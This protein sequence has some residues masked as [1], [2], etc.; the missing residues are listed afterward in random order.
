MRARE[1]QGACPVCKGIKRVAVEVPEELLITVEGC[2][3]HV[4]S[5][6]R[7]VLASVL[8][9]I[10]SV[11]MHTSSVQPLRHAPIFAVIIPPPRYKVRDMLA[12]HNRTAAVWLNNQAFEVY[13]SKGASTCILKIYGVA[14]LQAIVVPEEVGSASITLYVAQWC[15]R[16]LSRRGQLDA[17]LLAHTKN[18]HF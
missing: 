9:P 3:C 2:S 1:V 18:H 8:L 13:S 16:Y 10:F 4:L 14:A 11:N 6:S 15:G 12:Q 5:Y 17:C 7:I